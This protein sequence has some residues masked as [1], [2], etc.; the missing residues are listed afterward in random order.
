MPR[1]LGVGIVP[2]AQWLIL[3]V[4]ILRVVRRYLYRKTIPYSISQET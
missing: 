4:L 2:L 3:P 1:V